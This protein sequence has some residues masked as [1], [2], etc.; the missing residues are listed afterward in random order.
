MGARILRRHWLSMYIL[1]IQKTETSM[2]TERKRNGKTY[3]A[4]LQVALYTQIVSASLLPLSSN[5]LFGD[6]DTGCERPIVAPSRR[7]R[8]RRQAR[9]R[10]YSFGVRRSSMAIFEALRESSNQIKNIIFLIFRQK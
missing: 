7:C 3:Y 5:T 1:L 6:G 10:A 4:R 8:E 2:Q 9:K